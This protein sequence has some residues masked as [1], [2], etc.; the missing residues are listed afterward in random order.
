[1]RL[2]MYGANHLPQNLMNWIRRGVKTQHPRKLTRL[3][4]Q[5][6]IWMACILLGLTATQV[7]AYSLPTPTPPST[8]STPVIQTPENEALT[9]SSASQKLKTAINAIQTQTRQQLTKLS[10][11]ENLQ[12]KIESLP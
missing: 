12:D 4:R 5:V 1:M 3:Q 11:S 7:Q 9:N 8:E 2:L 6:A 10:A